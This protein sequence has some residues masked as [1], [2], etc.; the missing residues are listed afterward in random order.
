MKMRIIAAAAA[1]MLC[2]A[3]ASCAK[4]EKEE[5]RSEFTKKAEVTESVSAEDKTESEKES[6]ADDESESDSSSAESKSDSSKTAESK[7]DSSEAESTAESSAQDEEQQQSDQSGAPEAGGGHTESTTFNTIEEAEDNA[8]QTAAD[9]S[10]NYLK[11]MGNAFIM[12]KSFSGET[13]AD[14]EYRN[15][16][17]S[18]LSQE[19]EKY[20]NGAEFT[21]T[22]SEGSIT[23]L[24]YKVY[25][26]NGKE[27]EVDV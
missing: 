9:A 15:G 25:E 23:S 14:G 21:A 16:D 4:T 19:L 5:E 20:S 12:Q 2:L 10:A 3:L 1:A 22:V 8:F 7:S 27:Y 13:V 24:H 6:K 17:G 11:L 26:N 18:E